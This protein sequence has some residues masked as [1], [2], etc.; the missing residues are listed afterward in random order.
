M[1]SAFEFNG[2]CSDSETLHCSSFG[3]HVTSCES[4]VTRWT[5]IRPRGR[6]VLKIIKKS[7]SFEN[8]ESQLISHFSS[9][10]N[11]TLI[12]GR[13]SQLKLIITELIQLNVLLFICGC[14]NRMPSEKCEFLYSKRIVLNCS[15]ALININVRNAYS[16]R[17]IQ[18][19]ILDWLYVSL[20]SFSLFLFFP[21]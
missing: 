18:P 19:K 8:W 9:Q 1:F 20:C 3:I 13:K 17:E 21:T 7:I 15:K 5:E 10:G 11:I 16:W 4:Y 6:S 2:D 12:I 14:W